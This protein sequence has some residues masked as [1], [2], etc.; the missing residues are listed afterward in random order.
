MTTKLLIEKKK[1][2]ERSVSFPP[3]FITFLF[4]SVSVYL[5]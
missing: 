4:V 5:K 1:K 2:R 3:Y